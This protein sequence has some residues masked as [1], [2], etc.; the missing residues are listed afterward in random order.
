MRKALLRL[1]PRREP[2]RAM[3]YVTPV[4]AFVSTLIAGGILF[5][6]LGKD[7]RSS[8]SSRNGGAAVPS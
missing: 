1:E 2:S 4:L 7:H 6:A 3:L 8:H 5:W